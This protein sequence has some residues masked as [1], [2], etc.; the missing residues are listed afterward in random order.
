MREANSLRKQFWGW[1]EKR[2]D[3]LRSSQTLPMTGKDCISIRFF[4]MARWRPYPTITF[5]RKRKTAAQ[6]TEIFVPRIQYPRGCE[7]EVLG[8][9][10]ELDLDNQRAIIK[11]KDAGEVRVVIRR[12]P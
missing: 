1:E 8:G 9:V 5:E 12:K 4:S 6:A 3:T 7:I 10:A 11:V 2:R